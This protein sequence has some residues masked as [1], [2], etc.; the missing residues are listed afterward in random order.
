MDP[1][2]K[3]A[4]VGAGVQWGAVVAAAAVHGLLPIAGSSPTVGVVGLL[5]GGGLGPLARSHG[6]A[7]DYVTRLT[8]VTGLGD[9]VEADAGTNPD[10]FWALRGGKGGLGIVT[11]IEL[12]LAEVPALYAGAL[13]FAEDDIEAAFRAWADWTR[14]ANPQVTT[15]AMVIRFP[16]IDA[17]PAPFRGRRVLALRFAFPGDT[18]EGQRL[19]APLRAAAPVYLD[20]LGQM[21]LDD[22]AKIHSDPVQ[23]V[24]SWVRGALLT[25]IDQDF[26]TALLAEVGKGTSSP[27]FAAEVRHIGERTK[28][29]VSSGSAVGGRSGNYTVGYFGGDPSLFKTAIPAAAERLEASLA[30]FVSP[31]MNIN[32]SPRTGE[33]FARAWS[34]EVTTRLAEVRKR[35]DPDGIFPFGFFAA[36]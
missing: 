8:V 31:D 34:P 21:P 18:A 6:F 14:T 1:E 7:S 12:R 19:A 23:P 36:S 29:D 15:S 26:A 13:Y 10:L 30:R 11:E 2:A 4:I 22:V 28:V 24:P 3:R 17:I 20:T 32:F 35:Y 25:H 16:P 33:Q 27:L 9:L 5:V